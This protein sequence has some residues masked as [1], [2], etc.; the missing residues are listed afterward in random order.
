MVKRHSISLHI[1]DTVFQAPSCQWPIWEVSD[2][3]DVLDKVT[4]VL[5]G[6]PSMVR[7]DKRHPRPSSK[8]HLARYR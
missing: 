7:V 5:Y 1:T 4:A 6:L 3:R 2:A 8:R